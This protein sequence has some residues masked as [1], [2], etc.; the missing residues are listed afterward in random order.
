MSI[1]ASLRTTNPKVFNNVTSRGVCNNVVS[2]PKKDESKKG[3]IFS[4]SQRLDNKIKSRLGN[5]KGGQQVNIQNENDKNSMNINLNKE[6]FSKRES[7]EVKDTKEKRTIIEVLNDENDL[8]VTMK[9]SKDD[10]AIKEHGGDKIFREQVLGGV[11]NNSD[12][13]THMN[14]EDSHIAKTIKSV[15]I[16]L[17]IENINSNLITLSYENLA[18][19]KKLAPKFT[20]EEYRRMFSKLIRKDY[21]KAILNHFFEEEEILDEPLLKH[22]V[23][24]RMRCRMV[25]W[26]IEVLTNYKCDDYA[27]F[28]AV[29]IMDKYFKQNENVKSIQPAELHLIGIT[30]MFMASKYQD[31]YPLRLKVVH[32]KIAHKKLTTEEIK[33]KEEDISRTL[34]YII[35]RPTQW[36]FI[37]HFVEEI[38][39]TS[40]NFYHILDQNLFDSYFKKE[41]NKMISEK[42]KES[43]CLFNKLYTLNMINLLKHVTLYLAKMNCHEYSLM[44]KKP[45]LIASSTI[46]VAMKICEQI[47]KEDYVNEYFTKRLVEISRKNENEI[48]KCAQKILYNA[49]NFDTIFTGLENLKRVHFN[50]IIELK[51]TK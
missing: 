45:S 43:I 13:I 16:N 42:E 31:I 22:K 37:N 7:K 18:L 8:N 36:D 39:Y 41:D 38:F 12:Q 49:Q 20:N 51:S 35:G 4:K 9:S 46:Y 29:G 32:E 44:N 26:M 5:T 28:Y 11:I 15:T 14:I 6:F 1:Q 17:P 19:N 27:F 48:I 10:S 34:S 33:L 50:A 24:E 23:S 21:S 40:Y 30:S 2:N 25:D 47:N 3:G